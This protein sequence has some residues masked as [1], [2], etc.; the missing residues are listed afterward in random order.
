MQPLL[1]EV[2]LPH[3]DVDAIDAAVAERLAGTALFVPFRLAPVE[4]DVGAW[5]RV[6]F[7]QPDGTVALAVE[8]VV[9]WRY[10]DGATPVG[11]EPGLGVAIVAVDVDD[12][13]R[14]A[15]LV[16][17]AGAGA[18]LRIPGH[19]LLVRQRLPTPPLPPL[20]ARPPAWTRV[21]APLSPSPSPPPPPGDVA[22]LVAGDRLTL[23]ARLLASADGDV[24]ADGTLTTPTST[25][26]PTAVAGASGDAP[27]IGV[28]AAAGPPSAP[29]VEHAFEHRETDVDLLASLSAQ[30]IV[31]L[32]D[33]PAI[34]RAG[35]SDADLPSLDGAFVEEVVDEVAPAVRPLPAPERAIAV[36]TSPPV[37]SVGI[38]FTLG[39]RGTSAP[40]TV[41]WA[42]SGSRR[43]NAILDVRDDDDSGAFAAGVDGPSAGDDDPYAP[44]TTDPAVAVET[45]VARAIAAT[46]DGDLEA[47][48][49][50]ASSEQPAGPSDAED[51][52][53]GAAEP[54]ARHAALGGSRNDTDEGR[55]A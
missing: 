53:V 17:R 7:V 24:T 8:G 9:A 30:D 41:A 47:E 4:V 23:L 49:V 39:P 33:A 21:P 18:R 28:D 52:G 37:G 34:A 16:G 46:R 14:F 32:G 26:H 2:R 6:A 29:T 15:A 48:R 20:P 25:E 51:V 12:R 55:P 54:R 43:A 42:A 1:I 19:R 44:R 35:D 27:P 5:V 22:G 45:V 31:S 40:E 50:F 13:G 10:P 11:H 36:P 38:A 3:R